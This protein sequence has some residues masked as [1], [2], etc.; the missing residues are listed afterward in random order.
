MGASW[1]RTAI[2]CAAGLCLLLCGCRSQAPAETPAQPAE[3]S[4]VTADSETSEVVSF[5][6]GPDPRIRQRELLAKAEELVQRD[7]E[8]LALDEYRR[9]ESQLR[10]QLSNSD[11]KDTLY[12]ALALLYE[13]HAPDAAFPAAEDAPGNGLLDDGRSRARVLA[14]IAALQLSVEANPT[15]LAALWQLALLQENFDDKLATQHWQQLIQQAPTHLQAL[16]RLGEGLLLLD[17][18]ETARETAER[19]LQLAE[20]RSDEE[21][22]GRARNVLGRAYLHQGKY[23]Q[24]EEMFKNAAVRKDGSHWGCAYQSLGQLYATL[25]D[26][27]LPDMGA[28]AERSAVAEVLSLYQ[29]GDYSSALTRVDQAIKRS[30][31]DELQV[32]RGFLLFFTGRDDEAEPLFHAAMKSSSKDPG[33]VTGLAHLAIVRGDYPRANE[34]LQPAL[35]SWHQTRLS[36]KE[37]PRYYAFLHHLACLAH[38]RIKLQ[39]LPASGAANQD[40]NELAR[41]VC[42]M[43]LGFGDG[44]D[45]PPPAW[46]EQRVA[47]QPR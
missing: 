22:A 47:G 33:P 1:C 16:T 46:T 41:V 45:A 42:A 17:K 29:E 21:E 9:L 36:S 25:G 14:A 40:D 4:A 15:N 7:G 8:A 6:A 31:R 35:V 13:F 39:A 12:L 34:L 44:P 27:K 24:A 19:A 23:E 10:D 26:S 2:R 11:H 28:E 18:H 37:L 32:L 20:A 38:G 30:P 3:S 5:P 43:N